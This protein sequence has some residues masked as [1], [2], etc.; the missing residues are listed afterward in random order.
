MIWQTLDEDGMAPM[1]FSQISLKAWEYFLCTILTDKAFKFLLFCDDGE[2]KLREWSTRS[3]PPGT[4]TG[5]I[6]W[7]TMSLLPGQQVSPL[8]KLL[9][10]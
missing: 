7:K 2:W 10:Y 3:Y 8:T 1:M 4:A 5:L 9:H 6:R